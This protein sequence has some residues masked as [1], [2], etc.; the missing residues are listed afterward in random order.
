MVFIDFAGTGLPPMP[1]P[2]LVTDL[3]GAGGRGTMKGNER[4]TG[5]DQQ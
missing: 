1:A 3:V 4:R 2:L 5:S